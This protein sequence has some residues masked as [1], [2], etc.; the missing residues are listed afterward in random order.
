[1]ID[2]A[3]NIVDNFS[4][5]KGDYIGAKDQLEKFSQIYMQLSVEQTNNLRGSYTAK[6]RLGWLRIATTLFDKYFN[7]AD[8]ADKEKL[9]R[10]FFALYSFE[11]LEFGF[12]GIMDLISVSDQ[13]KNDIDLAK[14]NWSYFRELTSS[15]DAKNNLEKKIFAKHM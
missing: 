7:D 8:Y 1:M 5:S 12:D 15:V 3:K 2:E 4:F 6:E 13:M 10:I 14:Q 9:I 11:N